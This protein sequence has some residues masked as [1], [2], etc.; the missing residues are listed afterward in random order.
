MSTGGR[1]L[2]GDD[3]RIVEEIRRQNQRPIKTYVLDRDIQNTRKI[4]DRLSQ[5][6]RL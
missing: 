2:V 3:S 5:L 6:A 1:P 4:N